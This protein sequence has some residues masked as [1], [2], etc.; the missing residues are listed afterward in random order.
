MGD[1]NF[2]T[3]KKADA[4]VCDYVIL[5]KQPHYVN[6]IT[7]KTYSSELSNK[8]NSCLDHI[9][10]NRDKIR[11]NHILKPPLSDHYPT[12]LVFDMKMSKT[13]K[14]IQFRDFSIGK[15]NLFKSKVQQEFSRFTP[16][17]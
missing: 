4:T 3:C 9:W 15:F 16:E 14:V 7:V 10:H 17:N 11:I 1:F 2:D 5:I 8:D 12:S 13:T 6:E